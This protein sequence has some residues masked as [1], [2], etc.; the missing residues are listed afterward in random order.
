[1]K[2]GDRVMQASSFTCIVGT[3]RG[4]I[5]GQVVYAGRGTAAESTRWATSAARSS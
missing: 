1:M 3:P 2:V 5:A 4:G